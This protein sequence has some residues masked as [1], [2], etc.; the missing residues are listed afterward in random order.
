ML[1]LID[2]EILFLVPSNDPGLAGV[3]HS[4]GQL[5][6]AVCAVVSHPADHI[7]HTLLGGGGPDQGPGLGVVVAHHAVVVVRLGGHRVNI[8]IGVPD[9][10]HNIA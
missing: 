7:G 8:M 10:V 6:F 1:K 4:D 3:A 2:K 9:K 5:L